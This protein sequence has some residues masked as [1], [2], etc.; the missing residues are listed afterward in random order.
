MKI[1]LILLVFRGKF[2][3]YWCQNFE[4]EKHAQDWFKN[5][6]WKLLHQTSR[7]GN[8]VVKGKKIPNKM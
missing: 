5:F 1:R 8:I 7:F 4:K 3:N 2:P 6:S